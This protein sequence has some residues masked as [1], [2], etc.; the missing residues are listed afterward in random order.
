MAEDLDLRTSFRGI[1]IRG[2]FWVGQVIHGEDIHGVWLVWILDDI[3]PV[4]DEG[5]LKVF[6]R[7]AG[8]GQCLPSC[9]Q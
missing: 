5:T 3:D 1:C 9:E 2:I 6:E 7:Q 8:R 4:C